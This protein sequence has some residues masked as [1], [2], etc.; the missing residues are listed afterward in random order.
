MWNIVGRYALN[1]FDRVA[2]SDSIP[3]K[4]L[5]YPD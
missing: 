3:M 1:V 4:N 5:T 2:P